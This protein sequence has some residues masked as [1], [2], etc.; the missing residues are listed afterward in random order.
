MAAN[1]GC[2]Y[3]TGSFHSILIQ[4]WC[5][6]KSRGCIRGGKVIRHTSW[7]EPQAARFIT[8]IRHDQP[9]TSLSVTLHPPGGGGSTCIWT[10]EIKRR[11]YRPR[12]ACDHSSCMINSVKLCGC[13]YVPHV[14]PSLFYG[15]EWRTLTKQRLHQ[16]EFSENKRLLKSA[17][18]Y[19]MTGKEWRVDII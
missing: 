5:K 8:A 4:N 18:G 10:C 15:C 7:V 13:Y 6:T 17:T 11:H 3:N 12:V 14:L 19:R 1:Y 9:I 2:V 16:I